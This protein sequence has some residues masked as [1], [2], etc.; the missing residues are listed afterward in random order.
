[1]AD[2]RVSSR[3]AKSLLSLAV[4]QNCLEQ[5]AK[6]M[7][8]I[9]KVIYENK[10][11][12]LLLKS[13]IIKTDKKISILSEIFEKN[14]SAVSFS[15]I[16]I[17]ARKKREV[18]L[19][20]IASSFNTQYKTLKHIDTAYITTAVPI[21]ENLRKTILASIK[22]TINNHNL[23][24]IEKVDSTIIGGMILRVGDKQ[25]DESIRRKI[26]DLQKEFSKNPY[27]KEY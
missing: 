1:M 15:F 4:E 3:Y 20:N 17:I 23:E 16:K 27:I 26:N 25:I 5:V 14:I 10:P 2:I 18:I 12:L 9:E 6:D 13:P 21:D 19:Q 8:F 24:L 22:K 7:H 11:L